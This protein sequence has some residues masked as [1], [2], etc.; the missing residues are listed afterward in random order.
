MRIKSIPYFSDLTMKQIIKNKPTLQK[1]R[2]Q[3]QED[4]DKQL[5]AYCKDSEIE[6]QAVRFGAG[7]FLVVYT[8]KLKSKQ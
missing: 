1:T 5:T 4:I 2:K 8:S 6:R 3:Y 7:L